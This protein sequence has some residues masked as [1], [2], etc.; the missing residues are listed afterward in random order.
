MMILLRHFRLLLVPVFIFVV[1]ST[2]GQTTFDVFDYWPYLPNPEN[3]LYQE[4]LSRAEEQ[5]N[6]RK[7]RVAALQSKNDWLVRQNMVK[8]KLE[9]LLLP[10]W[11]KT[12]LKAVITDTLDRPDFSVEKLIFESFPGYPVSAAL[13]LPKHKNGPFPAILFCSGHSDEGFRSSVYQHM[14]INYV[15]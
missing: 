6:T 5:L 2:V 13:F 9:K 3:T 7:T 1:H 8:E 12:P 15:K 10:P 14:I 11:E 4:I